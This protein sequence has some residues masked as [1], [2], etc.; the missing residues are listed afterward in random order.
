MAVITISRG[1]YA[2]GKALAER[3]GER[4][5]Y[6]VLG[7][8]EL[9]AEAAREYGIDEA[10]LRTSLDRKPPFWREMP[11][12]AVAYVKCVAAVLLDHAVDGN[13]IY[14]GNVGHLLLQD[15]P[16]V[17]RVRVIAGEAYRIEAAM[18][19]KGLDREAALAHIRRVDE[20]RHRWAEQLY[21]VDAR[22]PA[23][24]TVVLNIGEL[25]A[26][27]ACDT[28]VQMAALEPFQPNPGA[29]KRFQDLRLAAEVW[30]ALAKDPVTRS[31]G[32]DVTADDGAVTIRGSAG[33]TK[34]AARIPEL[35][36][37]VE[38][39]RTVESEAGVGT[40]WFW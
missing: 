8:E 7:R 18:Q 37:Q 21:G 26:D 20:E 17:L 22:D 23:Q 15:L 13:L 31:A 11:G 14:H 16:H 4:L 3:L 35:A 36:R 6:P 39:V 1:S 30:A 10:E 38:G 25:G 12:K 27:G 33:T 2:G 19:Q 28:I 32:I 34:A 24:Y 29:T 9:L 5:E 40:D